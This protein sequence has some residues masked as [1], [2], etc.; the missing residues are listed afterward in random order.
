MLN[1]IQNA[2]D[3]YL[4]R[5]VFFGRMGDFQSL[6]FQSVQRD[7]FLGG[8]GAKGGGGGVGGEIMT[9]VY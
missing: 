2:H 4:K 1:Q 7:F 6:S 9:L 3:A 8:G 5:E